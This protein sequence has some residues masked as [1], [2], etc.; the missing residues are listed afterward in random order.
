MLSDRKN[1]V[2]Q[3]APPLLCHLPV[4]EHNC[5]FVVLGA[6]PP[7]PPP[8]SAA[9]SNFILLSPLSPPSGYSSSEKEADGNKQASQALVYLTLY[10]PSLIVT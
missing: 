4:R 7:V 2:A 3:V 6:G 5:I 8:A 1:A 9:H 10:T